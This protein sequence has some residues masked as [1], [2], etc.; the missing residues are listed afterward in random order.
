MFNGIVAV[1]TLI[2]ALL[3][4]NNFVLGLDNSYYT[5]RK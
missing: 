3:W 2:I 4:R 1:A 5:E